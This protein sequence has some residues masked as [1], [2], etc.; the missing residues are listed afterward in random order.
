MKLPK[1]LSLILF[2]QFLMIN[3]IFSTVHTTSVMALFK[4]VSRL[5]EV[6]HCADLKE[7]FIVYLRKAALVKSDTCDQRI[8]VESL[9]QFISEFLQNCYQHYS[10]PERVNCN[11]GTQVL[12]AV[13][14]WRMA[15]LAPIHDVIHACKVFTLADAGML[16]YLD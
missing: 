8:A 5:C 11:I 6:C 14:L 9:M 4:Q 7:D 2:M 16:N 10:R 3:S 13:N 12:S 1:R 15:K